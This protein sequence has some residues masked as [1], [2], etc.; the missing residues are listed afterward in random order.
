M[1]HD[2]TFKNL[3][4]KRDFEAVRGLLTACNDYA[5]FEQGEPTDDAYVTAYFRNCPLSQ[6]PVVKHSI[7]VFDGE[8]L[9]GLVD[10]IDG[11]PRLHDCYL[12]FLLLTPEARGQGLGPQVLDWLIKAAQGRSNE[13]MLLCVLEGNEGAQRFWKRQGFVP[14]GDKKTA[15]IRRRKHIKIEMV[16][17]LHRPKH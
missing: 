17:L 2:L 4:L 5:I 7:G 12:G 3:S 8:N 10:L 15:K 1:D 16:R 14:L 6:N 13:R 9:V 11:Y